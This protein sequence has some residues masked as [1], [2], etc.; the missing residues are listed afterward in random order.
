VKLLIAIFSSLVPRGGGSGLL[1]RADAED[2]NKHT[3]SDNAALDN[4]FLMLLG[5]LNL[6]EGALKSAVITDL[7]YDEG[8]G[9]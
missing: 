6:G 7:V 1:E 3:Y 9:I 4:G 5:N 2:Y 8:V